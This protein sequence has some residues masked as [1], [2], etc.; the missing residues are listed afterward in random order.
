MMATYSCMQAIKLMVFPVLSMESS[1]THQAQ[2]KLNTSV[3]KILVEPF[4]FSIVHVQV[5]LYRGLFVLLANVLG[6]CT[7]NCLGGREENHSAR[8]VCD[9]RCENRSARIFRVCVGAYLFFSFPYGTH[10]S[11]HQLS[12]VRANGKADNW[13]SARCPVLLCVWMRAL[14]LCVYVFSM[15]I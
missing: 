3:S 5:E 4:S 9:E 10:T 12:A 7:R 2:L 14:S 11:P 1:Y 6:P 15:C 8:L 13:Y